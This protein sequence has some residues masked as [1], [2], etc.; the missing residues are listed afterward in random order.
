M[1]A[2]F[3]A[4]VCAL[5]F[6]ATMPIANASRVKADSLN[7]A[8]SIAQKQIE[9]LRGSGYANLTPSQMHSQDLI[10]SQTLVNM[11]AEGFGSSG[12][13]G[14]EFSGVDAAISDNA[15]RLLVGGRGFVK[16]TNPSLELR[17]VEVV[18]VWKEKNAWR[19]VRVGTMVA[20]L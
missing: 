11:G 14:Y 15:S 12:E 17:R 8:V 6:S 4:L 3:L 16:V 20:N 9:R 19:V 18:V 13:H 1:F 10:D 7:T 5:L 2:S